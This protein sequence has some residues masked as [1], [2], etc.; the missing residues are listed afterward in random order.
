MHQLAP[1]I[2]KL[3]PDVVVHLA[4]LTEATTS[5]EEPE[6]YERVNYVG[7]KNILELCK[8]YAVKTS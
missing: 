4:A 5:L 1:T 7:T 2:K 8:K 6:K 3:K